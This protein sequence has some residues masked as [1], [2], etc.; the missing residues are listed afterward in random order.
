MSSRHIARIKPRR[1]NNQSLQRLASLLKEAR[2]LPHGFPAV[3]VDNDMLSMGKKFKVVT[4]FAVKEDVQMAAE[5][6]P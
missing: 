1:Y 6:E 5:V 2:L 4:V 3:R